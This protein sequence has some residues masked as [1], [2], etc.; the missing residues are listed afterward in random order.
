M[1]RLLQNQISLH[2]TA[3]DKI[4]ELSKEFGGQ[5][6]DYSRDIA[7]RDKA[8]VILP[9][10]VE[11]AHKVIFEKNNQSKVRDFI[12]ALGS[13]LV[14]SGL[15]GFFQSVFVDSISRFLIITMFILVIVGLILV[16]WSWNKNV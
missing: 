16:S 4:V 10:H 7:Q 13:G 9:K 15:I 14:T 6:S 8:N 1:R 12:L 2:K 11:E 3:A 5:L